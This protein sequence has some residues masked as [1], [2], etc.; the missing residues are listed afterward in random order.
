[1][2]QQIIFKIINSFCSFYLINPDP[3]VKELIQITLTCVLCDVSLGISTNQKIR[4]LNLNKEDIRKQCF[5]T[6]ITTRHILRYLFKREL[7]KNIQ[8][9][10]LLPRNFTVQNFSY[11]MLTYV[12]N[13]MCSRII[14]HHCND[15][16]LEIMK[17]LISCV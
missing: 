16:T 15:W 12:W 6:L 5:T 3:G 14:L 2:K 7:N 11:I 4:S 9:I 17:I 13:K 8:C 10:Y 1:M